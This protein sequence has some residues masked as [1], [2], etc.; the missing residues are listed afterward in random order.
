MSDETVVEYAISCGCS[1][2]NCSVDKPD[3]NFGLYSDIEKARDT[4][5]RLNGKVFTRVQP[6]WSEVP[7]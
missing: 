4:A 6:A 5:A 1:H 7:S 3:V 2:K